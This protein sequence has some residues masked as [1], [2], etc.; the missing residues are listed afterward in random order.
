MECSEVLSSKQAGVAAST[1]SSTRKRRS[2]MSPPQVA[3]AAKRA[4]DPHP[5]EHDQVVDANNNSTA[6]E[7]T[8]TVV[9][10]RRGR[11]RDAQLAE[12]AERGL[13]PPRPRQC[14]VRLRPDTIVVKATGTTSCR[15]LPKGLRGWPAYIEL[16]KKIDDFNETCLILELMANKA[17]KDRHWLR[18]SELCNYQ[19]NVNSENFNLS[20]VMA[21]P[22]LQ[23]KDEVE[24]ICISAIKEK[25]IESKLKLVISDW[26]LV[27][28]QFANFKLRGELLLRGN[29]TQEIIAKLEDALMI[30]S[31]LA[32]N[33]YN[34]PFKKEIQLWQSKLNVTSEVLVK[35]LN[36]QNLWVYLEAVFVGGDI[37]KQLPVEAKRF[38]VI[39]K[40]W[41]KLMYRAREKVNAVETCSG[42]E[43]MAKFLPHLLEQLELCQKS[44]SG[45]KINGT[46]IMDSTCTERLKTFHKPNKK[47][48][49]SPIKSTKFPRKLTPYEERKSKKKVE[50]DV[51]NKDFKT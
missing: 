3:A 7:E 1:P 11:R 46:A 41:V 22:I 13:Q 21:A 30:L 6:R 36:V 33:R 37:A 40:S 43:T 14:R 47:Y 45:W 23:F 50:I 18:I 10:G 4:T 49:G 34:A 15:R 2:A 27:D 25:D 26:S 19:F 39:D 51:N 42:D 38:N 9:K 17:V 24:D 35:W 31:S 48:N 5:H 12:V 8:F 20:S 28:L 32:T 29:E 44:L 16:K